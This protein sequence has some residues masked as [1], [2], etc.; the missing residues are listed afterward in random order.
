MVHTLFY[1]SVSKKEADYM[2]TKKKAIAIFR[3]HDVLIC[4]VTI[5]AEYLLDQR[6]E[7]EKDVR[8]ILTRIN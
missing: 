7:F 1:D 6:K 5:L 4:D 3:Q 2:H 8:L